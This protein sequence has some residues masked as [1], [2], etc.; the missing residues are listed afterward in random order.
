MIMSNAVI[1][2]SNISKRYRIGGRE[3]APDTFVEAIGRFIRQPGRGLR[4]LRALTRFEEGEKEPADVIWA[5]NDISF[6][7]QRG[8]VLGVIGRNGAGKSTLLKLLSRIIFPT[9]GQ[10]TLHGRVASLLEVGTGFHPELTGREN[11]FLNGTLLGMRKAE[12]DRKYDEIIDFAGVE[13]FIDTPLKRYSSGMQVR[14]AFAVA[15]HLEA[16]I[17]LVDEVLSVG[18]A[19]FQKKSAGKMSGIVREGRTIVFVSH[20]MSTISNICPKAL[21]LHDGSIQDFGDTAQVIHNYVN[22][23]ETMH[24]SERSLIDHPGHRGE[25]YLMRYVRLLGTDSGLP[26]LKTGHPFEF[27]VECEL[28]PELVDQVGLGFNIRDAA[29][30]HICTNHLDQY[31]EYPVN[32][33]RVVIVKAHIDELSLLPGGYTL[34]LFLDSGSHNV[35]VVEDAI[36]FEVI[37]DED[38]ELNYP[39]RSDWGKVYLPVKWEVYSG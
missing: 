26:V 16:D 1:E 27:E 3:S 19:A 24:V 14:L 4:Q 23:G 37:W 30:E 5:L 31:R 13:K 34:S 12:I 22:M 32:E 9:T 10:I 7:V 17:L 21:W 18:D 28:D 29:G 39:P 38:S 2:V 8:E 36:N 33:K 11:I 20:N 25:Y 35:D 15:S 6:E